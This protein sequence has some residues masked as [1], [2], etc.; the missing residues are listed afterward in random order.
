MLLAEV[1]AYYKQQGM[2]LYDGLQALYKKYGYFEE[3]TIS[4]EFDGLDGKQKIV[5]LMKGFRDHPMTSFNGVK[6]VALEDFQTS[7]KTDA[8]GNETKIDLP[9]SNVL[10]YWLADGTWLAIR[11]SGTEP[12]IKFYVGVKAATQTAANELLDSYVNAID[13]ELLNK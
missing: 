6:V 4:E 2:T 8:D 12:K 13:N 7:V 9:Q 3:K 10:K 5:D 11:P 1:A